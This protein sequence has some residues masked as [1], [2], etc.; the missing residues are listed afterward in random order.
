MNKHRQQ[1]NSAIKP[2]YFLILA[3]IFGLIC[4]VAL[5]A[6]NQQMIKLRDV[7]Y[8]ADKDNGDVQTALNNLQIYVTSHMNTNL[9]T[10]TSVYPPIQLKYTYDRLVQAQQ[11][12]GINATNTQ[13][14]TDAQTFCQAQNSVDFSGHNRV[15]CIEQYVQAHGGA[16]TTPNQAQIPDSLYKFSFATPTWSPDLA[17]WTLLAT[18]ISFILFIV[19]LAIS[20]WPSRSRSN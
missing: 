3:L 6:N 2:W 17:G 15:P 8:S 20:K 18:I 14:Y 5:R 13:L 12:S 7:V 4:I 9:S 10:G 11:N 1:R 19:T 16:V